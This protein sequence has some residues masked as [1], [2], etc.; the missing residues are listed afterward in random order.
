MFVQIARPGSVF[1]TTIEDTRVVASN[2]LQSLSVRVNQYAVVY[3]Q[4]KEPVKCIN[5]K[6]LYENA[7]IFLEDLLPCPLK[8]SL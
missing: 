6:N 2:I 5:A 1:I 3:L 4:Y 7:L 8:V